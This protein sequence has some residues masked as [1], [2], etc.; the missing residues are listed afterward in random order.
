[1]LFRS[2]S[3]KTLVF[4]GLGL[5]VLSQFPRQLVHAQ[6]VTPNAA[7]AVVPA[8]REWSGGVGSFYLNSRSRLVLDP[9]SAASLQGTAQVFQQDLAAE[10]GL[11]LPIVVA[12]A[13]A[14]GDFLLAL[15]ST[16]TTIGNE[17]YLLTASDAVTIQAHT[18]TGV[19]YGTRSVLQILNTAPAHASIPRGFARDYPAYKERGFM[20]DVGRRF[21]P[22]SVLEDY[23]RLMS[24]Y[25]FNDFQLHLNDNASGAGNS[26]D[27]QH[28]YAAFRLNSPAFPGLAAADGSYTEAQIRE[29]V[30]TAQQRGVTITPEID[31]PAHSLALTQYRP[32]LA[33]PSYEKDFLDL[34]NPA[35]LPF[36]QSLWQT[37]LPWF[38]TSEVN[39]G[40]DE[41]ATSDADRFRTYVNNLDD[42]FQQQGITTRMWGS[43]TEMKSTIPV[44]TRITI[45]DWNNTWQNPVHTVQ[46]GFQ[47]IN[48][49]DALLYIVPHAN[50]YHDFLD[51]HLLYTS[52]EPF[53]FDLNNPALNLQPGDP[54]LLGGSFSVW[55]DKL[56]GI[57]SV[58]DI[59]ERITPVFP[60]LGQKM[61]SATAALS[62]AQFERVVQQVGTAPEAFSF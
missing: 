40:M 26:T 23:V 24:W 55:N 7:P 20:L 18:A 42:F 1:M 45:Q 14:P 15:T 25:K 8:L 12:S 22:L 53:I 5:A 44:H 56:A 19:F 60:V 29:L 59:T 21:V 3:W 38:S 30:R 32:D 62:Y 46:Q 16:D 51:T 33:S 27:W 4:F 61:W 49:N 37:F 28:Q 39:M 52:W 57:V 43:L 13:P 58:Q 34:S 54:H 50:Y 11:V 48:D 2:I 41:Y 10:T 6:G 36:V 9:A 17:G 47:I 35:T 31:T